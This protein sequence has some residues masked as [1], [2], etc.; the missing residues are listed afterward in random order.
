MLE[1]MTICTQAQLDYG[2]AVREG[3]IAAGEDYA[4]VEAQIYEDV[5]AT[6]DLQDATSDLVATATSELAEY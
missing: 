1:A 6:E 2:E 4:D 3:C 5:E